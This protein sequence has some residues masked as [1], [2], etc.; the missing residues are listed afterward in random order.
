M[1]RFVISTMM[2][3]GLARGSTVQAGAPVPVTTCGQDV[4]GTGQLA[5]DLDCSASADDAVKLKGTLLLNGFSIFGNPGF[6]VVRCVSGACRVVGPGL[7]SGGADGVRSDVGARLEND[8]SVLNNAGDGVRTEKTVKITDGNIGSN[9]GDGVR[10]KGAALLKRTIVNANGGTGVRTDGAAIVQENSSV[11]L[12]GEDGIHSEKIAKV[13]KVSQ[14]F[15][16]GFDGVRGLKVQLKDS[17]ATANG[18][19]PACGVTDDCADL[20]SEFAPKV[21]GTSACL[22]SRNTE[23]GGTWGVCAND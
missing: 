22:T 3:M 17:T 14:V 7:V 12:N 11:L 8:V 23:L 1:L 19:D 21:Q 18:T 5:A 15:S 4:Q 10:S 2:V 20:A 13:M 9:G 16:N 6:D